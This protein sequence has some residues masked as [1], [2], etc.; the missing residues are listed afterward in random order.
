MKIKLLFV[1][2][3]SIFFACDGDK[4]DPSTKVTS[5]LTLTVDAAYPTSE[6]DDWI[7][8]HNEA[9]NL[10]AYEPF[11]SNQD[12][13]VLTDK[14]F[15]GKLTIT[16]LRYAPLE[17]AKNYSMNSFTN[18][19]SDNHLMRM[20]IPSPVT[21]GNINIS[22]SDVHSY[23]KFA[24]TTRLGTLFGG[25]SS[26]NPNTSVLDLQSYTYS[27]ATKYI[28]T[29]TSG[30]MYRYKVLDNVQPNHTYSLSFNDM[31]PS[32]E[33]TTFIFPEAEFISL[34]VYGGAPDLTSTYNSFLLDWQLISG[35][36]TAIVPEYIN[37]LTDYR[38]ELSIF[39]A[40]YAYSYVN[41][42]AIPDDISTWPQKSDFSVTKKSLSNF[43][44]ATSKS[45]VWLS[46]AWGYS[47]M[48]NKTRV[49]WNVSS[50]S[51]T[52]KIKELPAEIIS[53]HP[54][55]ALDNFVHGTTTFYTKS[56][57]YESFFDNY[58]QSGPQ[59]S[60]VRLGISIKN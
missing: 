59:P 30:N 47:D 39:Y 52:Y 49:N 53:L 37:A 54:A 33:K 34:F 43:S 38:T 25:S 58:L 32:E 5:L 12:L 28:L 10:L 1:V 46:T 16:F 35:P 23:Q 48:P 20:A 50:P 8:V 6:T 14:P 9:G 26:W 7:I 57:A 56:P 55:L 41:Q 21:S 27:G 19:E 11:E 51:P 18:I 22:V 45:F 42:G 13:E 3:L 2:V 60:G 24:L 15:K 36:I 40:D 31:I 29:V 44:T 4:D 17:D